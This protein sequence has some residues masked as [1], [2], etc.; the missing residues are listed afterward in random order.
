MSEKQHKKFESKHWIGCPTEEEFLGSN[1]KEGKQQ[2]KRA[3][4]KDRSKYKKSDRDKIKNE[5]LHK[6]IK[7]DAADLLRGRV[8]AITPEA[9]VVDCDGTMYQ[10]TMRGLLKKER[11]NMKNLVTVG[12]FVLLE[13]DKSSIAH[14]EPRQSVLSRADNLSRRKE[15]L[16]AANIDLV[17]ITGS[18]V[19]PPIKPSLLDRY[20]IAAYKGKLQPLIVINKIDLLTDGSYDEMVREVDKLL[21]D[22]LTEAYAQT[23]IPIIG[24]STVTGEGLDL[25]RKAMQGKATVFSGQSGVGK[26]SLI[27]ALTGLKLRVGDIVDKTQKGS[28]TTTSAQLVPLEFGGWCVDTP[29]IKSFGIWDLKREEIVKYYQEI[30]AL[31][32]QCH[33]PN[34]SH[35]HEE[36]CAVIAALEQEKLSAMRYESY[37]MLIESASS[38]HTRR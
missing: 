14:V 38:K 31:G 13:K 16:I 6:N 4:D 11:G 8:L 29:G 28:H 36:G 15:Q 17:I 12:D 3:M 7:L 5:G 18:V 25:L 37:R 9:I 27:N 34:C 23:D 19:S 26:S 33:F 24:V 10:C 22:E 20:I 30:D 32:G 1:R 2:R 35:T 21:L